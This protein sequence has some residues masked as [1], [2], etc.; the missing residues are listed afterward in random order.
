MKPTAQVRRERLLELVRDAGSQVAVAERIGKNKNQVHQWLLPEG[1][2]GA[3]NI[4]PRSAR[5]LEHAFG[6]P[7]FWMDSDP[8][9]FSQGAESS[10]TL[11]NHDVRQ[12][13]AARLIPDTI[14]TVHEMLTWRFKLE[15]QVY[16]I[17]AAPELFSLAYQAAVSGSDEDM[18]ALKTAVD[19]AL[20]RGRKADGER[21]D[22]EPATSP[23]PDAAKRGRR[24]SN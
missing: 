19:E 22:D 8:D 21:R 14:R 12:S 6:K 16:N 13:Y 5:A 11:H 9:A 7:E 23:G 3:R 15:A 10:L 17:E 2:D 20:L 24:G 4:G 18:S 1:Q